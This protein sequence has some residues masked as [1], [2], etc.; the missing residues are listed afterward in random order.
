MTTLPDHAIVYKVVGADEW[1]GAQANGLYRGS[2]DDRRDGFIHLSTRDQLA[3]TLAKHFAGR[4]DLHLVAI[5]VAALGA[6]LEWE[7]SRGGALFPHL[8][9]DLSLDA[10]AWTRLLP[11]GPDGNHLPPLDDGAPTDGER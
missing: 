2:A 6:A 4:D 10:I 9:G 11:L 3:G 8:Y 7:P 1:Q 5:P